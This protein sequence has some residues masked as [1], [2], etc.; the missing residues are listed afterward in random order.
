M[1]AIAFGNGGY[2]GGTLTGGNYAVMAAATSTNHGVVINHESDECRWS[3]TGLATVVAED[4]IHSLAGGSAA[5]MTAH[6]IVHNT[7]VGEQSACPGCS[8]VATIAFRVGRDM[9]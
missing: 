5:V 2:V 6:T 3:M 9:V 1:A 8:N 7:V 4:V